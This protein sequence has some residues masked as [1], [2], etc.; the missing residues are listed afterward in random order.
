[1]ASKVESAGS[2]GG[3]GGG[4]RKAAAVI[5]VSAGLLEQVRVACCGDAEPKEASMDDRG[6]GAPRKRD[7][8]MGKQFEKME[9]ALLMCIEEVQGQGFSWEDVKETLGCVLRGYLFGDVVDPKRKEYLLY[10]VHGTQRSASSLAGVLSMLVM[11]ELL[12]KLSREELPSYYA[13]LAKTLDQARVKQVYKA[14]KRAVAPAAPS[15]DFQVVDEKMEQH[16]E[17]L[18]REK[19]AKIKVEKEKEW[20]ESKAWILQ[21]AYD[22]DESSMDEEESSSDDGNI[23]DWEIWGDPEEIERKKAERS[24]EKLSRED[25][26]AII[27][28]DMFHAKQHAAKAKANGDKAG[29]KEAGT[30]IG[31]LRREMKELE[32]DDGDLE[33]L[34]PSEG[35][36]ASDQQ[37]PLQT[38]PQASEE[39]EEEF[40]ID[41]FDAGLDESDQ[42]TIKKLNTAYLSIISNQRLRE[43]IRN[44]KEKSNK[45][46]N[47]QQKEIAKKHPKAVLQQAMQREGWSAPRF[48][49]LPNGGERNVQGPQYRFQIFI[50]VRQSKN[51]RHG[52]RIGTHKFFLEPQLDGWNTIQMAQ[53]ACATKALMDL[54][55]NSTEIEWEL[56]KEPF[57]EL[58]L[59]IAEFQGGAS[60]YVDDGQERVEFVSTLM[61]SFSGAFSTL[62]EDDDD[63][64]ASHLRKTALLDQTIASS[65]E[66]KK[67]AL[68][69]SKQLS[70]RMFGQFQQWIRS[71][72]GSY[73]MEK[74]N[75]LPVLQIQDDLLQSLDTHDV[76]LVSGET[77][78]GKTTQVPQIVLDGCIQSVSG[79]E[80]NIVCT[81]PR[82]IAAISVAE[83]V[84]EERGEA[85]PGTRGSIVGYSVRFDSKSTAET[86][87]EFCTTGILLRRLSSDPALVKFSH[88]IVDEVH[89]RSMQSDFLIAML[90]DLVQKRR[91]L[92]MPLKVIL[93]SATM[94][95]EM[96]ADYFSGCPILSASGRTFPVRHLFLEDIY[97]MTNYVLDPDS[98]ASLREGQM[99]RVQ[100][101][102]L[103]NSAGSK[104]KSLIKGNWGDQNDDIILNP[105]FNHELYD[106]YRYVNR[107][108]C[109]MLFCS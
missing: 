26:I 11:N 91:D 27:A 104:N 95:T 94:N 71:E 101:K 109:Q 97:E 68:K 63:V 103:E 23:E 46:K 3:S 2:S 93:M 53:D 9:Q 106:E 65:I 5:D 81:Q 54:Y 105:H 15:Q 31:K 44:K 29:Q 78:S 10:E 59:E 79:A 41:M 70:E 77:G 51:R 38:E 18:E 80:C 6:S 28:H 88:V 21:Q 90:R 20:N 40:Q 66:T 17:E 16:R 99:S 58:L 1:M 82:R 47:T 32:I 92:G 89:E 24:R 69:G 45:K 67:L 48:E 76:V 107:A 108:L 50:D 39:E 74:R 100:Q 34:Y 49:K 35:A 96:V 56:L 43:S 87:L 75:S 85:G 25:K 83:R 64:D 8:R 30:I 42:P 13:E 60:R 19:E 37:S 102:K 52:M 62:D 57:D 84:S 33:P 98:P 7:G 12:C 36:A 72:T 86:R 73:W 22:D 61:Q 14:S 4:V 55:G